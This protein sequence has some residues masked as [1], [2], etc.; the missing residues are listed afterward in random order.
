M[1]RLLIPAILLMTAFAGCFSDDGAD[2]DPDTDLTPTTSVFERA[3]MPFNVT[4][5]ISHV[6][7]AGPYDILPGIQF[8]ES[9]DIPITQGGAAATGGVV[10]YGVHLPDI[11]GCDWTQSDLPEMCH[12]PVVADIG[13]Y[14]G[15]AG[16]MLPQLEGDVPV[17]EHSRNRLFGALVENLVPH[18]YALVAVSVPGT[19]DS[20]HCQDLGGPVEQAA[21]DA[22]VTGMGTAAWSNGNVGLI[23]RSYD[24]T[25]PWEAATFGNEH[26]KTIVPISGLQGMHDLMW[27]NGTS[28]DRGGSGLLWAIYQAFTVDGDAGEV[29]MVCENTATGA[30]QSL[31]AYLT[32]DHFAAPV[33]DY[34]T[35]RDYFDRVLENYDGSV[36]YIHGLQDW[37][38]DPHQAFPYYELLRQNGNEIKGLFGQ[39]DHAYPDRPSD[40]SDQGSGH[41]EEAFPK[42][43]RYDWAQDLLEWFDHYLKGTGAKPA[44]HVEVQDNMGTW[45]VEATYPPSDVKWTPIT[46]DQNT[47][48]SFVVPEQAGSPAPV[49]TGGSAFAVH[50][51]PLSETND[52]VIA[53]PA[54]LHITVTPS[55]PGGQVM[56]QLRDAE[57]GLRLGHAVMDL[58]FA[59][60]GDEMQPVA[61]GLPMTAMME[62]QAFDVVLPAG[63]GLELILSGAG[64]FTEVETGQTY[65]P[66]PVNGPIMVSLGSDSV[67]KLPVD[68]DPTNTFVPPV[69]YE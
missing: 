3:D 41:G 39:W 31:G 51:P 60:G 53:G 54:R 66:S 64:A 28:E 45:R 43:V 52:T 16:K 6:L 8:F 10:S 55:A 29:E 37:N 34:W 46:L 26:L 21:I 20:N 67:L 56:A 17:D 62:F 25:T 9:Y 35:S 4:D 19:G 11:E 63:H 57:T 1:M 48:T 33:N 32:G 38:V 59:A 15:A 12:L 44:L 69:W 14:Y 2:P 5:S 49:I 58:R 47:G 68:Q 22:A 27:R 30:M 7:E 50:L 18:G 23:G 65:L 61:P 36:Y 42:T 40:H 24:G 13:P